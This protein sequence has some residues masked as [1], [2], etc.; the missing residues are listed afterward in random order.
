M[1]PSFRSENVDQLLEINE[2]A[3]FTLPCHITGHPTPTVRWLRSGQALDPHT[4]VGITYEDERQ[5]ITVDQ[6]YK[7][8]WIYF[9][10][11]FSPLKV[12]EGVHAQYSCIAENVAGS[13][14][15]D[16]FVQVISACF[17]PSHLP[18]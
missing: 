8:K 11:M 18:F 16:F 15:R 1:P 4:S 17:F 7:T 9:F 12:R 5:Q 13:V 2:G 3:S 10:S 6:V 14:S